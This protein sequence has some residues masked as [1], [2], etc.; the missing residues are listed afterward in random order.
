MNHV[1]Y[2]VSQVRI[3]VKKFI[4]GDDMW[5]IDRCPP[6]F[7]FQCFALQINIDVKWITKINTHKMIVGIPAS[8]YSYFWVQ[9]WIVVL[10][11]N[12]Q[13][14]CSMTQAI[15]WLGMYESLQ[16]L[17]HKSWL[18]CQFNTMSTL[19]ILRYHVW[20][21]LGFSLIPNVR[22]TLKIYLEVRFLL[23]AIIKCQ[24]HIKSRET[25]KCK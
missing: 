12:K 25:C 23:Q 22:T 18:Y 2:L 13:W 8:C 15:V 10:K 4:C 7:G 24:M 1:S 16:L 14:L 21:R 20:K 19:F 9:F 3:K 11:H 5:H 6:S 17:G